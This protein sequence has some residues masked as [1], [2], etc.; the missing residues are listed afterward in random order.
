[1]GTDLAEV[2]DMNKLAQSINLANDIVTKDYLYQLSGYKVADLPEALKTLDIAEYTR[3]FKFTRMVSD[4]KESVI[5]KFV[6]VLNAA[7]S[8]N[9]TVITLIEGHKEYTDYYLGVVSKDVAQQSENIET[10]G[11]TLKGVLTGN[12]PGLELTPISGETKKRLLNNAFVYDYITSISGIASIRNEKDNSYEKFVQGIEHLVDSL[13]GREYSVVVI[14]DP[15]SAEEIAATKLGYESLY[16]QLSPFLKT[17]ISFNES[18]SITLTQSHT[19]GITESIGESTSLTQNYS[20]TSGWSESSTHG[21]STNK[22]T[23]HLV[24]ALVGAG[25]GV[26]ATV[27]TGGAAAPLAAIAIAGAAQA[28]SSIGSQVGGGLIGSSGKN[29]SQTTTENGST[30]ESSG[31]TTSKNKSKA[32]QSSNTNSEAEGTTHGKTLQFSNENKTVKNLLTTIDKQIE[33]LQ[34]C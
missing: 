21:T 26:A 5:D 1:M 2:Q 31:S 17:S 6:T 24:G 11:E 25:I 12:F 18:E 32:T 30:T 23:G 19:D 4:K 33:R 9:A 16:T 22:D 10:Q 8:S 20:K 13:Q 3:I 27:L 14:A 29:T 15:V 34:K 28:G 7:Y